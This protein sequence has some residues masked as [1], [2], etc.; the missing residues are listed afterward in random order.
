RRGDRAARRGAHCQKPGQG[1]ASPSEAS[2]D[3]LVRRSG[4]EGDGRQSQPEGGERAAQNQARTLKSRA[5]I[6]PPDEKQRYGICARRI[7]SPCF[8]ANHLRADSLDSSRIGCLQA[9]LPGRR[10]KIFCTSRSVCLTRGCE[11]FCWRTRVARS[12]CSLQS[13]EKQNSAKTL[14]PSAFLRDRKNI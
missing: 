5:S 9:G 4:D 1:G 3:R 2:A 7:R 8:S 10:Q 13:S 11:G 6:R 12:P 14:T